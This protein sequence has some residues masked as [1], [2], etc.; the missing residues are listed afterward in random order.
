MPGIAARI[1][2][3]SP[4]ISA[5][6][7]ERT[8][9][10]MPEL[11]ARPDMVA[12]NLASTEAN[13]MLLADLLESGMDPKNLT[14]PEA[15]R[16]FAIVGAH[17]NTP[18]APLLRA[19]R[20]GHEAGWQ[21]LLEI[22]RELVEDPEERDQVA[23]MVSTW[24]FAFIDAAS[25]LAEN[26]YN[27]ERD[28]WI[29]SVS[30]SRA[31]TITGILEGEEIEAGTASTRLGYELDRNH[32]AF[33]AWFDDVGSVGN[34]LNVLELAISETAESIGLG[35]PL[36][37]PLGTGA[38]AGWV[39]SHGEIGPV[40]EEAAFD[41]AAGGAQL[42]IGEPDNGLDGFHRSYR[43]AMAA[44]RVAGLTGSGPGTVTSYRQVAVTAMATVD[45]DQASFFAGR[46]LG[47]LAEG[48]ATSARLRETVVAFLDE[49]GSHGRAA[50]RLGIHENTVRYRV[51][52]AEET[53]GRTIDPGD[54]GLRIALS[55]AS[56]A[57]S[58]G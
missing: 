24:L 36:I 22:I 37:H 2:E 20:V 58:G 40:P 10:M 45:L 50:H 33:I 42:A 6:I 53:L 47:E 1:R 16:A 48:D 11:L 54:L 4:V 7:A 12:T 39:G 30:A 3:G 35:K 41:T 44:R 38:V 31:E 52:Q 19:Y 43:L 55:L 34:P 56:L 21:A 17:Q 25:C 15:T 32:L 8:E 14:L 51:R 28:R 23:G 57:G 49:G 27:D 29:R 5:G 26:T 9:A 18:L 46:Q 13:I